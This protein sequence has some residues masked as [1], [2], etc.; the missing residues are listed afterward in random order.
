MANT[1][2]EVQRLLSIIP[3]GKQN[4]MHAEDI[5]L[6]LNYPTEG[7]QVETRALIRYAIQQGNIIISSP[8]K[9]YWRSNN[10][11][12]VSDYIKALVA[13]AADINN[14]SIEVK[15]AWNQANQN[16]IIP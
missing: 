12:E 5:A 9:G 16:N 4:A 10:K 8:K 15:T 3:F 7:N 13:R 1:L 6:A 11:K 2:Q 14:R